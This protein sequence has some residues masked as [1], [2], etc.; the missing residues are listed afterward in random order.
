MLSCGRAS[1]SAEGASSASSAPCAAPST[2]TGAGRCGASAG[3][4]HTGPA[5]GPPPP[6][7]VPKVL[8]R[9]RWTTSKPR[10]PKRMRPRIALRFAPSPYTNAPTSCTRA[11]TCSMSRSQ[12]PRVFGSVTISAATLSSSSRSSAARSIEP[13]AALGT[14]VTSKPAMAAEAGLVPCALSGTST[15]RR[16]ASSPRRSIA[17]RTISMPASSPCAPAA[18]ARL[19][20]D[21]PVIAA[22]S[23]WRSSSRRSVPCVSAAGASGC[24]SANP[25][26]V[27]SWSSTFGLY[28]IVQEPSG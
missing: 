17:R 23:C 11:A 25:G 9:L 14:S 26:S 19:T 21:S 10:S 8:C 28:F 2:T 27:A 7:G 12:M 15:R 4:Q 3:V 20:A 1:A 18:G 6:C 22:S 13:S 24:R 16:L 5:P